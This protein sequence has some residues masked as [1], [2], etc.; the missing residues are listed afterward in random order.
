MLVGTY[1]IFVRKYDKK[2]LF[3]SI[4]CKR[5]DKENPPNEVLIRETYFM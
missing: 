1:H 4:F 2:K 5:I 3:Y